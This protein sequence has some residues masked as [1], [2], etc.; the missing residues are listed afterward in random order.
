M[1]GPRNVYNKISVTKFSGK[2]VAAYRSYAKEYEIREVLYGIVDNRC[3]GIT[4]VCIIREL[5]VV[6]IRRV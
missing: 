5:E 4:V 3:V 1:H 2:F 6:G